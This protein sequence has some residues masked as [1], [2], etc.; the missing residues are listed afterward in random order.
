[1]NKEAMQAPLRARAKTLSYTRTMLQILKRQNV[2][3]LETV[4]NFL[5]FDAQTE[6]NPTAPYLSLSGRERI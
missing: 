3:K 2:R 4:C 6:L 5:E 1:M